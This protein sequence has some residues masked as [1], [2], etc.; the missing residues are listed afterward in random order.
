M[1]CKQLKKTETERART[2]TLIL[3][4]RNYCEKKRICYQQVLCLG[5]ISMITEINELNNT[6]PKYMKQKLKKSTGKLTTILL[7]D[8]NTLLLVMDRQG[9]RRSQSNRRQNNYEQTIPNRQLQN[10][11]P[12]SSRILTLL[13]CTRKIL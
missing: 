6:A 10:L 4:A 8:F 7:E 11:P 12:N 13:T 3:Q 2:A 9:G 1:P 5:K